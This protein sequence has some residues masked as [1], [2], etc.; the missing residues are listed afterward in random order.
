MISVGTLRA[1][2]LACAVLACSGHVRGEQ[3]PAAAPGLPHCFLATLRQDQAAE[4]CTDTW[5]TCEWGRQAAREWG[6]RVGVVG[7][8]TK[9]YDKRSL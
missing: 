1:A 7:V 4:L 5:R 9:C 3:A 6:A 2:V 8:T